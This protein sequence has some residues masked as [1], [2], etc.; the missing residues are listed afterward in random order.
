MNKILRRSSRYSKKVA[1]F[2]LNMCD[3]I[4]KEIFTFKKTLMGICLVLLVTLL[5]VFGKDMISTT[6]AKTVVVSEG[7]IIRRVSLHTALP[8][9]APT[10]IVRVKDAETLRTQHIFYKDIKEGDY[11]IIYTNRV[12]IYDLRTDTVLGEK[13]SQ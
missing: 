4:M 10:S 3:L 8:Q 1:K 12:I 11:I 2:F 9:E 5:F 7:E 6:L 13:S